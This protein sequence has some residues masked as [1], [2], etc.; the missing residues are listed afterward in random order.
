MYPRVRKFIS[1]ARAN[2]TKVSG[3]FEDVQLEHEAIYDAIVRQD[4]EEAWRVAE[5]RLRNTLRVLF[6]ERAN[7]CGHLPRRLNEVAGP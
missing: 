3:L 6:K 7:K 5:Q 1:T 4:A 2:T